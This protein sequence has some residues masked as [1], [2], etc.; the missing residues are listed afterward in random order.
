MTRVR[1]GARV[2][3]L[4]DDDRALLLQVHDPRANRG[5]NP[6]TMDF[7]LLPGGGVEPGETFEEAARR[8]LLEETGIGG[9]VIGRCVW[10]QEKLVG[11]WA[12]EPWLVRERFFLGRVRS[13]TP[14]GAG[15]DE[16][17][18]DHRW[19]TRREILA[20]QDTETFQPPVLGALLG[21]IL[22]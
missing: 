9:V 20:R 4:D 18:V 8:E 7:W 21:E 6:I 16:V 11:G 10:T 17:I 12:G 15:D 14:V 5:H 3:L 2:V 22:G 13:G 1:L 19:F